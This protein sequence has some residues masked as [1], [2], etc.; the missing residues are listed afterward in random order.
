MFDVCRQANP[1]GLWLGLPGDVVGLKLVCSF[2][3][4]R[5]AHHV[6]LHRSYTEFR[7]RKENQGF[8]ESFL[9]SLLPAETTALD[10]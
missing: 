7:R 2:P 5:E 10:S 8:R 9:S 4:R 3:M 1:K 6:H